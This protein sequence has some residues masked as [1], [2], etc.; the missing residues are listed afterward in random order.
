VKWIVPVETRRITHC[1]VTEVGPTTVIR[2]LVVVILSWYC[3]LNISL[4]R[5]YISV[6]NVIGWYSRG[7]V[8]DP[9]RRHRTIRSW[10][11]SL[12]L[13]LRGSPMLWCT[14][15]LQVRVVQIRLVG[16]SANNSIIFS[17]DVIFFKSKRAYLPWRIRN[18]CEFFSIFRIAKSWIVCA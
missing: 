18:M 17:A 8:F 11:C 4:T 5:C 1:D 16:E 7:P 3:C 14:H 6:A 10:W 2:C 15:W 9:N 12:R 13:W